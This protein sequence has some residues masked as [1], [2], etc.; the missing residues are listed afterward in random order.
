MTER[1]TMFTGFSRSEIEQKIDKFL[2]DGKAFEGIDLILP[3]AGSATRF[4]YRGLQ[5]REWHHGGNVRYDSAVKLL[6]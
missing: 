1:T 3:A 2:D 6:I 5:V 4:E